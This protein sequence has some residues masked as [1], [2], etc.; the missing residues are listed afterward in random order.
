MSLFSRVHRTGGCPHTETPSP[1]SR[2]GWP[3]PC[4]QARPAVMGSLITHT[5]P[6]ELGFHF[7]SQA[8]C[9]PGLQTQ[10]RVGRGLNP[11]SAKGHLGTLGLAGARAALQRQAYVPPGPTAG[12]LPGFGPKCASTSMIQDRW[13]SQGHLSKRWQAACW[14][15]TENLA[16]MWEEATGPPCPAPQQSQGPG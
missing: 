8:L 4:L 1:S 16:F 6:R 13:H 7:A 12:K 10:L 2:P 14:V 9:P 3:E 11:A 5:R 15:I